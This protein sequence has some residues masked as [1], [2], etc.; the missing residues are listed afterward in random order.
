ME[1]TS[2][3]EETARI[4]AAGNR[5]KSWHGK[6]ECTSS[7]DE[8]ITTVAASD[9][10][11]MP[12]SSGVF[13]YAT[14]L[15]GRMSHEQRLKLTRSFTWV[16]LCAG[17]GTPFIAYEALRRA[18]QPYG[19]SPAGECKGLTE[20]SKDRRDALSR[21]MVH[22]AS[23]D[24]IF[25]S[26]EDL[27]SRLPKDEGGHVQDLPIVD[28]LF[29][30]IVCVKISRCNSTPKSLT[31]ASGSSGKSWLDFL[32]Y[33]DLL[34]FEER[35]T[36]ITLECV[37][38][39]NNNRTVQGHTE[40]GTLL[41]IEALRERGYVGQWR[42]V[43][44]T[45]FFLPQRRPRVWALFLKVRRGMGPKAI[46]EH[47]R[48][49]GQA[50]DFISKS[51]TTS[52]EA[53]KRILDRSPLPYAHRPKV[54]A[55][56]GQ[57]WKS[58][59]GPNFQSKHGLSDDYVQQGQD[60]FLKATADIILPRQQAAVWLELCRLRNKGNIPNWESCLLVSDCGSSVGWLCVAQDMCPCLRP[61]NSYLVLQQGEAKLAKGP[62]CLAL[63]GIGTEE[64]EAFSLL[65]EE[66]G[67]L[68]QLAGNA[69]CANV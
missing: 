3:S 33:L 20:K 9:G 68:R 10:D 55:S 60:A 18:L 15:V 36:T 29:M 40:K 58:T 46:R 62:L 19:L 35:P 31:D 47:E 45:R 4:T 17:L 44:A 11:S 54:P 1:G 42:K 34:T 59:Q 13:D 51:Q 66:D 7:S 16:D 8:Q 21:R 22:A 48:E 30:G 57:A 26:N 49:L 24:P 41:V 65:L 50:F 25:T 39:L 2:A 14:W 61:G 53:L 63:Q 32:K 12:N 37:D 43:S 56:R 38:N 28:H 5:T 69:F 67:L 27:T 64:A 6:A 23:S 52:H